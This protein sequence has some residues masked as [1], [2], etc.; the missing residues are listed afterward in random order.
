MTLSDLK[1]LDEC[2]AVVDLQVAVWGRDMETVPAGVL[3]VSAKRGGILIG[4]AEGGRLAGFVWSMPGLRGEVRSHWSHMLAVLPEFR[5]RGLAEALKLEQRQRAL[6]QGAD[7]VE[8][9]FDPLQA[10][11]AHLNFVCLGA[12]ASEYLADAYGSL[13]GPLHRGTPTDRLIAEWWIRRPHVERRLAERSAPVVARSAGVFESP[14]AV[15]AREEGGWMVAGRVDTDLDARRVRIPVPPCFGQ[16]QAQATPLALAWRM[17]TRQAFQ[18]YFGRG[19]R[20]VD[21]FLDRASGG[22]EYLISDRGS[23]SVP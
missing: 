1:T 6:A 19:Y 12:I 16:M 18:A 17:A 20:A 11:N 14:Y 2:R 4:A 7:L 3:L 8:W 22:G 13:S 21:F 5:G 23:T 15:E 10:G 9:T